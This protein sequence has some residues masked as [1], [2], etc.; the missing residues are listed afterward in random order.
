[1]SAL[2]CCAT[3]SLVDGDHRLSPQKV[4]PRDHHRLEFLGHSIHALAA[5]A[6]TPFLTTGAKRRFRS[7]GKQNFRFAGDPCAIHKLAP[8]ID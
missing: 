4:Y 1:L 5:A 6:E 2:G 8:N 3:V 7:R